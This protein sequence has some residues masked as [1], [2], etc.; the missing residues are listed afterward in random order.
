MKEIQ[1][2]LES[3]GFEHLPTLSLFVTIISG[4]PELHFET[5]VN[6]YSMFIT[7]PLTKEMFI[8]TDQEGNA[9]SEPECDRC[10]TTDLDDCQRAKECCISNENDLVQFKEAE[11]RVIFENEIGKTFAHTPVREVD[12]ITNEQNLYEV[13]FGHTTIEKAINAGVKLTLKK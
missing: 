5:W 4:R 11:E 13:R 8:T 2:T 6:K 12:Y 9:L 3:L 1:T 7:C 10:S